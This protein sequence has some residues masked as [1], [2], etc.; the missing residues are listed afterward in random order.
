VVQVLNLRHKPVF[1]LPRV[2]GSSTCTDARAPSNPADKLCK[3]KQGWSPTPVASSRQSIVR[4]SRYF[5]FAA[6]FAGFAAFF[7]GFFA[8]FFAAMAVLLSSLI[9]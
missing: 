6:F 5:F 2:C 3:R 4:E 8:A 9:A 1:P 7:A